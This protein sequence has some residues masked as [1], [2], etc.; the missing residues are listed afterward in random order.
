ME[1]KLTEEQE[2]RAFRL[3]QNSIIVDMHS[4]VHFDVIRLRG[5]G[6]VRV[7][8][9]KNLRRWKE[10][11]VNSVVLST[12]AKFGPEMFPYRGSSVNNLLLM[13]DAIQQ[14][15]VESFDHFLQVLEPDDIL[16]AREEGK[17][18]LML[19]VEGAEPIEQE[20]GFLRCYYRLG[21]R[22]M[23]LTW[24]H[25]NQVADGVAEPSNSGLSNFGRVLIKELNRLGII[26]DVS[27]LSQNGFRD[28]LALSEQPVIASHSNSRAICD[29]QRNLDDWQIKAIAEKGG[30]IGVAFLG[31]LVAAKN[32]NISRVLDHVDYI[33]RLVGA[34]HVGLGPD[35][36]DFSQD[37]ST[38]LGR[39][40]APNQ[41]TNLSK[42]LYA[43]GV[44]DVTELFSFT[45]GL[46]SRG[47]TDG[48]IQG[49]LGGNFLG[50]FKKIFRR[51]VRSRC[52]DF[53]VAEQVP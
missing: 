27:H 26:I 42:T 44:E 35:Y 25:R 47:Y 53:L 38:S 16:R 9:R 28:V 33:A 49:I 13:A 32:P 6:E 31:R 1:I 43:E 4:D 11:G 8:E 48:E 45:K 50:V 23:N 37:I 3:H 21:L 22:I 34:D 52:Q 40:T 15:I 24:H 17:I 39:L 2:Q 29:H 14:E 10:G 41:P 19:G 18:G 30:I 46:V 12:L 5:E 51:C 36:T 7:L 20:L